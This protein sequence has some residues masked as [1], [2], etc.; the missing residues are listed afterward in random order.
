MKTIINQIKTLRN[1][2]MNEYKESDFQHNGLM[3]AQAATEI[4]TMLQSNVSETYEGIVDD[5]LTR[6]QMGIKKYGTNVDN[7]PLS[8][9]EWMQHAYEEAL[10][11]SVYLKRLMRQYEGANNSTHS[12]D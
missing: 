10:D 1:Q 6:E 8:D 7:A 4:I 9:K 5:L 11:F 3:K 2:W 12:D